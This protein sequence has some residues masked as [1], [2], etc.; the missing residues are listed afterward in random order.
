M[1]SKRLI[2]SAL[3]LT[4]VIAIIVT[5][6]YIIPQNKYNEALK[7]AE[8]GNFSDAATI[9][10]EIKNFRD[11]K[12]KV[13]DMTIEISKRHIEN[14]EPDFALIVISAIHTE[15]A[16]ILREQIASMYITNNNPEAAAEVIASL[17][18]K[19][20]KT[21]LT[22]ELNYHSAKT[23][24]SEKNYI[25][26]YEAFI[27]LGDYK[28]SA[29]NAEKLKA[30]F[31]QKALYN[32][33]T[34]Q[35]TD[36][37]K[38][39]DYLTDHKDYE[40]LINELYYREGIM[41]IK[42]KNYKVAQE[43]FSKVEDYRDAA[44]FLDAIKIEKGLRLNTYEYGAIELSFRDVLEERHYGYGIVGEAAQKLNRDYIYAIRGNTL[45]IFT[46]YSY[47]NSMLFSM[48]N[49]ACESI[50]EYEKFLSEKYDL[51]Y[52]HRAVPLENIVWENNEIVSFD[53]VSSDSTTLKYEKK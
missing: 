32:I 11:S 23:L 17:N 8:E 34:Y 27:A 44:L 51:L 4:A 31:F 29:E 9:F 20:S 2:I 52:P 28:D 3:C 40:F 39:F 21:D 47:D 41:A 22:N 1:K 18:N 19:N 14:N 46:S 33:A 42:T 35:L 43:A 7:L 49:F 12:Q 24:Q 6:G 37:I 10:S 45:L 36:A 30:S 26:A 15:E 48:L 5:L 16:E 13:I 25:G 53:Y 38:Y 50:D